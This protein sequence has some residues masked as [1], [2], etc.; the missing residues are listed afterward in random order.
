MSHTIV[1]A[2]KLTVHQ[3]NGDLATIDG[4]IQSFL[5][6]LANGDKIVDISIQGNQSYNRVVAYITYEDQ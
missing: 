1:D 3:I 4:L 6:T 2:S 5:R